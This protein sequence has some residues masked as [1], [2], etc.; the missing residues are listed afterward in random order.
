MTKMQSSH[1]AQDTPLKPTRGMT[2]G[3]SSQA[4]IESEKVQSSNFLAIRGRKE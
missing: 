3:K 1:F 4:Q 2:L